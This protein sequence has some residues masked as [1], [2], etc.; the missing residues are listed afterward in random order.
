MGK[1]WLLAALSALVP[2]Q[3]IKKAEEGTKDGEAEEE[4]DWKKAE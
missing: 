3:N 4:M 1:M 2:G